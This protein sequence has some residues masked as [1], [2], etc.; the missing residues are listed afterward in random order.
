MRR[1]NPLLVPG[2]RNIHYWQYFVALE[3][4]LAATERFVEPAPANMGCYSVEFARILLSAGAEIDVLCKVLCREHQLTL[5]PANIDGYCKAIT[6]RFPGFTKLDIL[7]P[8]YRLALLPWKQWEQGVNPD[9]WR[10]HNK[11]KHER[12]SHFASANLRNALDAV[13]G[14]FVLASYVCHQELRARTA[15][16]WPRMLDLDPALSS[17]ISRFVMPGHVLP[18]FA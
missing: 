6:K 17:Y 7:V 4:D 14:L 15:Q 10:S 5:D 3:A 13:A 11:V 9:W 1:R 18:D 8:C 2:T 16:P 12:H